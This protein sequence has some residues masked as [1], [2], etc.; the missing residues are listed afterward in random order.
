MPVGRQLHRLS[1]GGSKLKMAGA[2]LP[3]IRIGR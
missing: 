2:R 1:G 3:F